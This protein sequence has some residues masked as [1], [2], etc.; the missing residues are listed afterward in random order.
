MMSKIVFVVGTDT[1][2]GK[3]FFTCGLTNALLKEG[4]TTLAL[5]PIETGFLDP[6]RSDAHLLALASKRQLDD[7][8]LYKFKNPLAPLVAAELEGKKINFKEV[9]RWI[10]EKSRGY[11][12]TF[13]ETAGGLMV[14]IT[15]DL[16][17]LELIADLNASAVIVAKNR[18]G[19]IN[20]TLLT[21]QALTSKSIP[22]LGVIL[23]EPSGPDHSSDT[24]PKVISKFIPVFVTRLE[25]VDI[26]EDKIEAMFDKRDFIAKFWLVIQGLFKD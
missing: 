15:E 13:V 18:L 26:A 25:K 16:T 24:N 1:G 23:N 3:T 20:H 21:F 17:Y 2:V 9:A 14:P 4:K 19:T 11:D 5:K 6:D 12:L 22:V 8:I 10:L 7:V